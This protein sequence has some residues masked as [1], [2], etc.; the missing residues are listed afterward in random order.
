MQKEFKL[1]LIIFISVMV[2]A[3]GYSK[4]NKVDQKSYQIIEINLSGD[5]KIGFKLKN[6]LNLY[7]PKKSKNKI[8]MDLQ[9]E[10][11]ISLKEKNEAGNVSKRE[12]LINV[13]LVI[14]NEKNNSKKKRLFA[15]K[16]DYS[17]KINRSETIIVERKV[18]DNLTQK[19]GEEI[20]NFLN[21]NFK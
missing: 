12:I 5:K 19:M 2:S 1:Y 11:K 3:C 7:A 10:K 14:K 20:R 13:N 6:Y 17:V 4:L 21:L 18:V 8:I 9:I 15:I 16:D